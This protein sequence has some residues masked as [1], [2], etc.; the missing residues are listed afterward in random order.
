MTSNSGNK[1]IM[2]RF[3]GKIEID[4]KGCWNWTDYLDKKGYG[5]IW[6]KGDKPLIHRFIYEYY[7]GTISQI[8]QIN[9]KCKNKKCCNPTHLEEVTA[10][11]N[12]N[13]SRKEHMV[14]LEKRITANSRKTHCIRGHPLTPEN[15]Y[16]AKDR[17]ICKIC[18]RARQLHYDRIKRGVEIHA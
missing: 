2:A 8:L 17:R 5:R 12:V 18:C 10:K 16:Y 11:V 1:S 4:E 14:G 15:L 3:L 7:Y 9:H 13:Y 6:I